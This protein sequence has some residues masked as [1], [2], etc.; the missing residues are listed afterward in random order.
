MP[1]KQPRQQRSQHTYDAILGAAAQLFERDGYAKATT[2][3][4]AERAGVSIGSLYQYF[5]NKD[6]LLY[7]L[8]EQH[9]RH[10]VAEMDGVLESLRRT[11][12]PLE[13]TVRRFVGALVDLHLAEPH[14]H[15]L[16]FDQ[17]PRPPEAARQ[18]REIQQGMAAEVA[19]HLRRLD[20]GGPGYDLTALLLVQS[21]EGMLH[22]ALLEPPTG[23]TTAEVAEAMVRFCLRA[24]GR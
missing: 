10:L 13:D 19:G 20:A 5:P 22:G 12:P 15:R 24:L 4:I 18:L 8:G 11:E 21:V 17:A 16:L 7:A 23:T 1:R 6:A 9:M 3:H 2:N 14:T